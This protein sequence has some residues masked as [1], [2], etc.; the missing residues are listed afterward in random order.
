MNPSNWPLPSEGM[1]SLQPSGGNQAAARRAVLGGGPRVPITGGMLS[2]VEVAVA[3]SP[4]RVFCEGNAVKEVQP[5]VEN[6][7]GEFSDGSV[8]HVRVRCSP[9]NLPVFGVPPPGEA[10]PSRRAAFS[11]VPETVTACEAV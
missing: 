2:M 8:S 9:I 6:V 10:D 3:A 1:V 11:A 7:G 5:F 4:I